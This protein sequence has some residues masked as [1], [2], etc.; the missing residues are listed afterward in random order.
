MKFRCLGD[1]STLPMQSLPVPP[2]IADG[3]Q[4]VRPG[5]TG[6]AVAPVLQ[7][8]SEYPTPRTLQAR[9]VCFPGPAR[10]AGIPGTDA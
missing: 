10:R 8:S 5:V 3:P 4:R 1:R 6:G 2:E 7:D 9:G